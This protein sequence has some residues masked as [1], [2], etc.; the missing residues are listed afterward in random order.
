MRAQYPQYRTNKTIH[1]SSISHAWIRFLTQAIWSRMRSSRQ[2]EGIGVQSSAPSF[3]VQTE[4][5]GNRVKQTQHSFW[6][7]LGVSSG[8]AQVSRITFRSN[9]YEL[10]MCY[11]TGEPKK[12]GQF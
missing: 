12:Q 5:R 7:H 10:N 9:I 6:R 2:R 1:K 3:Q 11:H 4:L 8:C